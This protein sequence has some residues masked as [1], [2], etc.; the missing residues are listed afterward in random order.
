MII[1]VTGAALAL[2]LGRG[3]GAALLLAGG[4]SAAGWP[5]EQA[6]PAVVRRMPIPAAS[7]RDRREAPALTDV[8]LIV[9]LA[10]ISRSGG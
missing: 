6:S 4:L 2:A 8:L 1:A 5:D 10:V 9:A 7:N 3:L